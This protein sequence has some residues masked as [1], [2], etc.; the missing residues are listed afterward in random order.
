MLECLRSLRLVY[1]QSYLWFS[2]DRFLKRNGGTHMLWHFPWHFRLS[3]SL[4]FSRL[5]HFFSEFPLHFGHTYLD[6]SSYSYELSIYSHMSGRCSVQ[7]F[8]SQDQMLPLIMPLKLSLHS[9][10]QLPPE[11]HSVQYSPL[12]HLPTFFSS[13]RFSQFPLSLE[14]AILWCMHSASHLCFLLLHTLVGSLSQN[15]AFLQMSGV[16]S[17]RFLEL[18]LLP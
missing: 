13:R 15:F 10:E 14:S 5:Q 7:S 1:C 11:L 3:Y 9:S 12:V 18:S 4:Y 16:N 2:Q 6:D 8:D 17:E